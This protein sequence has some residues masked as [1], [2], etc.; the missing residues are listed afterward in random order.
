VPCRVVKE[1][2][3]ARGRTV[4]IATKKDIGGSAIKNKKNECVRPQGH[5]D[6]RHGVA[7][8]HGHNTICGEAEEVRCRRGQ[9]RRGA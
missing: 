3:T 5:H 6:K 9:P 1:T 8:E 4:P 7:Q 2:V